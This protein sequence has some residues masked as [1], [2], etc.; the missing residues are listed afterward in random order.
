MT[1][2]ATPPN[3]NPPVTGA[4]ATDYYRLLGVPY[5]ASKAEIR[6][7]YREAMKRVHPDR[8]DPDRRDQAEELA[9]ELNRAFSTLS[10][11]ESRRAYDQA[12]KGT[13]IQDQLMAQYAG[14]VG[15]PGA[16][17][18]QYTRIRQALD[19]ERR[20]ERRRSDRRATATLLLTFGGATALVVAVILLWAVVAAILQRLG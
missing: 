6:A 1:D 13:M 20:G 12:L 2:R 19:E 17:L 5:T 10:R 18:D 4:S 14:G 7:A 16:G 11:P 15:T 8:A 3:A 9:K